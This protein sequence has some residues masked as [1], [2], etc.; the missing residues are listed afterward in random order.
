MERLIADYVITNH[1]ITCKHNSAMKT[2]L[3]FLKDV[4]QAEMTHGNG[5]V[6]STKRLV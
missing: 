1:Q 6:V 5:L 4:M 2:T 3:R